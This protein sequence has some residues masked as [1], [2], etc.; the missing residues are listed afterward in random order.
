VEL[1]PENPTQGHALSLR[2]LP[3]LPTPQ[4]LNLS[5]S[6]PLNLSTQFPFQLFSFSATVRPM[7]LAELQKAV[8]ALPPH[9]LSQLAAYIARLDNLVWDEEIDRDFAPRGKHA[10]ALQKIDA[11][12]DAGQ[13]SE[14]E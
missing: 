10:A 2:S 9:E 3:S 6:Q 14:L 12:I 7:S 5:T 8:D 13:S 11:Q 4:P 1:S